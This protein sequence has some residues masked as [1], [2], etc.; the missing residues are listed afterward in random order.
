MSDEKKLNTLKLM[1]ALD[2]LFADVSLETATLA[3][4]GSLTKLAV[5]SSHRAVAVVRFVDVSL[6][7]G[8]LSDS[9]K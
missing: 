5:T 9:S 1:N 6:S 4:A 2:A 8:F 7:A 3:V